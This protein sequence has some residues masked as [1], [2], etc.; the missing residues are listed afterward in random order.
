MTELQLSTSSASLLMGV[1]AL[2]LWKALGKG[3]CSQFV[4]LNFL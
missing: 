3:W 2:N 4:V 1:I